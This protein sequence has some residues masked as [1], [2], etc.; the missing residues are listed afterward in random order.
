MYPLHERDNSMSKVG[1]LS[2][3]ALKLIAALAMLCDH[4]GLMFFPQVMIFR[5]IGRLAFPIFAFMIAE[6]CRYTRSKLRY[7]LTMAVLALAF[8]TVYFIT[9]NSLKMCIFVT[10]SF[11]ILIIYSLQYFKKV[12]FDNASTPQKKLFAFLLFL[13]VTVAVYAL[14][15][16]INMD[17]DFA[18]CMIPVFASLLHSDDNSPI[19]LKRLDI[20]PLNVLIMGIG[21]LWLAVLNRPIQ[22]FSLL[23]V[24]L[25]L[26]YSGKRGARKLKYFFYVFYPAH[27]VILYGISLLI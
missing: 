19:K 13:T 24:P 8:Q 22:L 16:F 21:L 15:L 25:L 27:L 7:L 11:S 6:G 1:F 4:V 3:N 2:G 5:I 10:F 26:L 23:S 9:L 17:Y 18:G 14:D 12:L 20:I